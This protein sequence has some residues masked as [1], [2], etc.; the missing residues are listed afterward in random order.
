MTIGA[1]LT[2]E[3]M[4]GSVGMG[5]APQRARAGRPALRVD[6]AGERALPSLP[7]VTIFAE[8]ELGEASTRQGLPGPRAQWRLRLGRLS[9]GPR[10]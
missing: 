1:N 9:L 7:V 6:G 8:E 5:T 4:H 2:M 3:A 10:P